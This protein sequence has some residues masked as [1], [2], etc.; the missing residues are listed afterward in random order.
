MQI[1]ELIDNRYTTVA[2]S[3]ALT[4]RDNEY[5]LLDS[6][7]LFRDVP[8]KDRVVKI[9]RNA[10]TLSLVETSPTG[11]PAPATQTRDERD[12]KILPTFRH[13]RLYTLLAEDL[14]GVREFG[15][16]DL[17][18]SV[19]MEMLKL[20]DKADRE[21]RQ[22]A[23]FLKW[24]ALKGRIFDADGQR[25]LLDVYD[26][27][28]EQQKLVEFDL[29]NAN[30]VD[31]IQAATDELLDYMESNALGEMVY[32]AMV[33]MSPAFH[34]AMME[35]KAFRDA[36]KSFEGMPNPNRTTLRSPFNFKDLTYMRHIGK[37][38]YKKAD[39]NLVEHVFVPANEA[40]IVP[41]LD[42]YSQE[43]FMSYYGPAEFLE[44]VN[45]YGQR[46]FAKAEPM[47]LNMGME[48]HTFSHCLHMVTKPRLVVRAR[49]KAT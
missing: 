19:D 34:K 6:L 38:T 41:I 22:T 48:I 5:G 9:E 43:T 23:E 29:N 37:C 44:T 4:K 25:L 30:A 17:D 11:T 26:K 16:D 14:Q 28:G 39:G 18:M 15:T 2:L 1:N 27:M 36:Y 21:Y 49:I 33:V 46:M 45:T 42:Q 31:P 40:I 12:M 8:I 24:G 35:N 47:K 13:S 7:G 10:Q 20:L 32:G 3:S